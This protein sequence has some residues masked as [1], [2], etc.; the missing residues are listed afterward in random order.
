MNTCLCIEC[1]FC[2]NRVNRVV[3][4]FFYSIFCLCFFFLPYAQATNDVGLA[5]SN[6][7]CSLQSQRGDHDMKLS[8]SLLSNFSRTSVLFVSVSFIILMV[9]SLAWLVF[10]YV[11]RFRYAHAKDRLARR[12]FNAAK[13]A[14]AKTPA[15]TLRLGDKELN[16]D[17]PVCIEPYH[18]GDA[19]RVLICK[20]V[21]HKTCVDPWLLQHRTCPM[22]KMDF[23]KAFGYAVRIF[24]NL[25]ERFK[26]TA[27]PWCFIICSAWSKRRTA[28]LCRIEK[29][30]VATPL[31]RR[32]IL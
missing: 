11:Q 29:E 10:Y 28:S 31:N 14:L 15:K 23:L 22:C 2:D 3:S 32:D 20:H 25:L 8:D 21:F 27:V 19:V 6:V 5:D 9:I 26:C 30:H 24:V 16:N 18:P 1:K 13:K 7:T 12:L 17:C 4:L